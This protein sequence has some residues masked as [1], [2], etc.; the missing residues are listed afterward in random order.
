MTSSS[1][2]QTQEIGIDS[3]AYLTSLLK[4]CPEPPLN[5]LDTETANWLQ[6]LREQSTSWV[7]KLRLP[8]KRD[9]EWRFTDLSSLLEVDFLRA[10]PILPS[11]ETVDKLIIPETAQSYVVFVN[12][13]YAPELSDVSQLPKGIYVGNLTELPEAYCKYFRPYLGQQPGSEEVFTSLNRAGIADVAIIWAAP[14][15]VV[16]TPIHLLFLSVAGDSPSFSQPRGWIVAEK[17][18]SLNIVEQFVGEDSYFTNG[19]TEIWLGDNAEINHTRLQQESGKG[20]HIGK[21]AISQARDSRYTCH[22]IS[23]GGKLSRHNLEVWQQGEQTQTYL[24]GL[25]IANDL[26]LADTHSVISLSKPHGNTDQ[27]HKCIVSDRAHGVFSGKVF[28]PKAAQLTNAAQLNQNLLL[29]PKA[30][31]DTKPE[32]QITADN[33]KC[34]HGATVSQL[35]ADEVFYLRS[36]GLNESDA[37]HLLIDAFAMEIIERIPLK[38]LR[39]KISQTITKTINN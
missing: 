22:A 31:V 19:V 6:A 25:T 39:T 5:Q 24:N 9:E 34:S 36:R 29:S 18:C 13:V 32:L 8:N 23:L 1:M 26:Q 12:G 33:V 7:S 15:V 4:Q 17:N 38:S 2:A 16:E 10:K 30:R 37:R 3:D 35:E 14:N 28:V 21:S 11:Q 27:L 20:V